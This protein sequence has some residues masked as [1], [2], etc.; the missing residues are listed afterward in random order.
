MLSAEPV[1]S[2][3]F[4]LVHLAHET[5]GAARTRSSL[6][7]LFW[8]EW[9]YKTRAHRAARSRT[10]IQSSSSANGSRE[11]APDDRLRRVNQYPEAAVIEPISHGVLDTP[12][13]RGTTMVCGTPFSL[14]SLRAKRSNPE[15]H[16]A[17]LDCFR[18]RSLSYGGQVAAEPVIGI[19][20]GS[21]SQRRS[22]LAMTVVIDPSQ[23]SR[24]P[25]HSPDAIA[26]TPDGCPRC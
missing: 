13:S 14:P 1:C 7:P 8:G 23:T 11:C 5:A 16:K 6:R 19:Q 9:T 21:A 2:C 26:T 4:L 22:K 17:G 24:T 18:L 3:A 20:R 12:L 25:R 10:H 15:S